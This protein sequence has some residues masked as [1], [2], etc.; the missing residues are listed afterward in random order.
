MSDINGKGYGD[1]HNWKNLGT[2]QHPIPEYR[3]TLFKCKKCHIF[4]YHHYN[5]IDN[6]FDAM[7]DFGVKEDC[8]GLYR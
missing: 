1:K 8:N 2:E 7:R 4:F 6:I 5:I 3:T